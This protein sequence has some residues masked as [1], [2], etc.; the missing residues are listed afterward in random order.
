M[1]SYNRYVYTH[2]PSFQILKQSYITSI[3]TNIV[4]QSSVISL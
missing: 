4:Y 2:T 1:T 3:V